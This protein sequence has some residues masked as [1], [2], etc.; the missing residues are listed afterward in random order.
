MHLLTLFDQIVLGPKD[1]I[2]PGEIV[3][4]DVTAAHMLVIA[5]RGKMQPLAEERP[6]DETKDWNDK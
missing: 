4:D 6:F 3:T 1:T 5:G 2:D